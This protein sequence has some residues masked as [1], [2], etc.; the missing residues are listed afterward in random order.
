MFVRYC[1]IFNQTSICYF[2]A[3]YIALNLFFWFYFVIYCI[4]SVPAKANT[5]TLFSS[6]TTLITIQW[7]DVREGSLQRRY[8]I[9]WNPSAGNTGSTQSTSY[10]AINLQPNTAYTFTI[11]ARN[12][13]G[14]G[15]S[16]DEAIFLTGLSYAFSCN[17]YSFTIRYNNKITETAFYISKLN[18][19]WYVCKDT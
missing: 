1:N 15:Q 2:L 19:S 9:S 3:I 7:E 16:S 13:A 17:S 8:F 11:T 10:R 6:T 12:D 5:P 18:R 4:V 14:Y